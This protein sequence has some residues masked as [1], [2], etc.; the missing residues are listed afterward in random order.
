MN[1]IDRITIPKPRGEIVYHAV[2]TMIV[3]VFFV[4][5]VLNIVNRVALIPSCLWIAIVVMIV[6]IGIMN[7]G[8]LRA[9]LVNRLGDL[10]S[11]HFATVLQSDTESRVVL[12]GFK[13][14]GWHFVMKSIFID[15]IRTVYWGPGQASA[16]SGNDA[17]DWSLWVG[18]EH[19][20][21][22]QREKRREWC[23]N[24]DLELYG[25]GASTPR[26][27][28]EKLGLAL[29]ALLRS[30]GAVIAPTDKATAFACLTP[31]ANENRSTEELPQYE[32][33]RTQ[34]PI[35]ET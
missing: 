27:E 6:W 14:L 10:V 28:A 21:P 22:K 30:A 34:A 4:L 33:E 29:I 35:G 2:M 26:V 23:L 8:N 31:E 16:M 20:D 17:D 9:F 18:F 5:A 12:F 13:V 15:R 3:I 19:R 32:R 11:Q 25:V 1:T 7:A 24:P